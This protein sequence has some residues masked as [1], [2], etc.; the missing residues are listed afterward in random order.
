MAK[1]SQYIM[2]HGSDD[3]KYFNSNHVHYFK[4][5][6]FLQYLNC[7]V[8]GND[9]FLIFI[10]QQLRT[11]PHTIMLRYAICYLHD[12]KMTIIYIF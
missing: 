10:L 7:K 5:M 2:L 12:F 8:R 11:R 6:L 9:N 3:K 4:I 1:M